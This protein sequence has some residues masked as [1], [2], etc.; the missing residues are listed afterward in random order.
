MI[1][2]VSDYIKPGF[3]EVYC[4]PMKSGKTR[5]LINRIDKL[6][7]IDNCSFIII[8]PSVDTRDKNTLKT[9]FGNLAYECTFIDEDKPEEIIDIVKDKY[10]LVIIDEAHF[11]GPKIFE[12]LD[13]L[14]RSGLHIIVAGLDLNF[15]GEPFG[16]MGAILC[17]ANKVHKLSGICNHP[18]CFEKSTRTQKTINGKPA[19]YKS[20]EV[21]IGDEEEGYSCRCLKHHYID[22]Y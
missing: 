9:R 20:P 8:K 5:E 7:Y 15:R 12:T 18:D 6:E 2:V 16:S 3:L 17:L 1:K 4:G 21:V 13:Y 10:H 14:L 19:P 11:F 22:K